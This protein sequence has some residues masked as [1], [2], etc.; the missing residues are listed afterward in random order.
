[1]K[2]ARKK[3]E[4]LR[5]QLAMMASAQPEILNRN[6][7]SVFLA[8]CETALE[9]GLGLDIDLKKAAHLIRL[10]AADLDSRGDDPNVQLLEDVIDLLGGSR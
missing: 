1:M 10:V 6:D 3:A 5:G 8:G 9:V 4:A 7:W 2:G